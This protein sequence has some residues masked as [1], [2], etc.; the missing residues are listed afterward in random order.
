MCS[1]TTSRTKEAG[2]CHGELS[3]IPEEW[4][5][6][7]IEIQILWDTEREEHGDEKSSTCWGWSREL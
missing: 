4:I 3:K 1:V 7:Y 2:G 5:D 6:V